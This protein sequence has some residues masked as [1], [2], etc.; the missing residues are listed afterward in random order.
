MPEPTTI[1]RASGLE[2]VLA[3]VEGD[4]AVGQ[5]DGLGGRA[6]DVAG[7]EARGGHPQRESAHLRHSGGGQLRRVRDHAAIAAGNTSPG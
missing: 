4:A 5:L 1:T 2:G 7:L 3:P 6:A